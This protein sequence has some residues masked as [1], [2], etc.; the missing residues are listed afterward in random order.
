[1]AFTL[2]LMTLVVGSLTAYSLL[3][4]ARSQAKIAQR[5]TGQVR[6]RYLAEAGAVIAMQKLTANPDY[7]AGCPVG[8]QGTTTEAV[9]LTGNG[10]DNSDPRVTV[11]VTNCGAGRSHTIK[12]TATY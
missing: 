7:P 4:M 9:D 6:A 5:W 2:A 8:G 1:M 3:F 11:V 10:V 12:A